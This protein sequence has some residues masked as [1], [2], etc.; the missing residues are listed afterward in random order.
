MSPL[1]RP[2]VILLFV[3][4]SFFFLVFFLFLPSFLLPPCI[5]PPALADLTALH[6]S[7]SSALPPVLSPL[8]YTIDKT[9]ASS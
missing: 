4:L 7:N 6:S 5:C 8:P 3:F 1:P 2:F 9:A